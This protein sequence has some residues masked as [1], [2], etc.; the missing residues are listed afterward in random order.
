VAKTINVTR[1]QVRA[2]QL[3][4]RRAARGIG[5]ASPAV[6]AI[7]NARPAPTSTPVSSGSD[8]AQK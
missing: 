2:A 5:H 8:V 1:A 6:R 3:I 4:V 7:A